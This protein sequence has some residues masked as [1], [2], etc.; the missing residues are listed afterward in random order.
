MD[1]I[2]LNVIKSILFSLIFLYNFSY[3][4]IANN[5]EDI[6]TSSDPIYP[7]IIYSNNEIKIYTSSKKYTKDLSSGIILDQGNFCNYSSPYTLFSSNNELYIY[8]TNA[9]YSRYLISLTNSEC[10]SKD[11]GSLVLANTKFVE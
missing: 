2:K 9:N 5:P 8:C 1:N 11:L 7:I 10:E 4:S 6:I 3:E